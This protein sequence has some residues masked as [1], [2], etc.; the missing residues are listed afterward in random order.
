[1]QLWSGALALGVE[2]VGGV[3]WWAHIGGFLA[4]MALCGLFARRG[5]EQLPG[6]A[7]HHV[8]PRSPDSYPRRLPPDW[9]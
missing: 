1:M 3:A 5:L 7:R 2:P 4:G 6:P 9:P 8:L